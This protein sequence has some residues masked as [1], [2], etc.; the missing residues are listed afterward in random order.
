MT[1]DVLKLKGT[2]YEMGV[3]QGRMYRL[4][5]GALNPFKVFRE[6]GLV[7]E[8]KPIGGPPFN[9][10]FQKLMNHGGRKIIKTIKDYYPNQYERLEGLAEGFGLSPKMAAAAFF[11]ENMSGDCRNDMKAPGVNN[12][13]NGELSIP[14]KGC[15]G[16]MVNNSSSTLLLKNYDFPSELGHFQAMRYSNLNPKEGYKTLTL[17]EGPLLGAVTGLNEKGLVITMNAGYSTDLDL[18]Q[19]PSTI[20]TQEVLETCKDVEEAT[21][22]F[23]TAPVPVGWFFIMIDKSGTGRIIERTPNSVGIREMIEV[24]GGS[25]LSTANTFLCS[26]T[27]EK[28]WPEGTRWNFKNYDPIL[29][30]EPSRGRGEM[31]G[32][33]LESLLAKKNGDEK[34]SVK[35]CHDILSSHNEEEPE[36]GPTT[37]CNHAPIYKTLSSHIIDLNTMTFHISDGNPCQSKEIMEFPF[38]FDY[39]IPPIRFYQKNLGLDDAEKWF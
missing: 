26:E 29:V 2:R 8:I 34:I 37:I 19:P 23:K 1:I 22:I 36:G 38:E 30:L 32:N 24:D 15:T 33:K 21:E 17:T 4:I 10:V 13:H 12:N 14:P 31:L 35:D 7:Q 3:Q 18:W 9:Y 6:M 5:V 27:I 20:L 39:E 16:G 11:M 28:Q 25:Y